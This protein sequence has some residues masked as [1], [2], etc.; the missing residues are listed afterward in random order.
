MCEPESG[1]GG[2]LSVLSFVPTPRSTQPELYYHGRAV[3]IQS[4]K[5]LSEIPSLC[6]E[7]LGKGAS[8]VHRV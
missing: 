7:E 8:V 2:N 1:G 3:V 6:I 4:P 5:T